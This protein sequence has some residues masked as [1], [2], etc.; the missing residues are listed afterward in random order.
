MNFFKSCPIQAD[1]RKKQNIENCFSYLC[2]TFY[3]CYLAVLWPTLGHWGG[4][5]ST[6]LTLITV[7]FY[8]IRPK[9]YLEVGDK[10]LFGTPHSPHILLPHPSATKFWRVLFP[11]E[12]GTAPPS[13]LYPEQIPYWV[14][15]MGAQ[16]NVIRKQKLNCL[17]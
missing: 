16:K 8:Q 11:N 2:F 6:H 13:G 17:H 1:P 3:I 4:D 5:S 9:C 7:F 14:T 10:S 15:G 12:R